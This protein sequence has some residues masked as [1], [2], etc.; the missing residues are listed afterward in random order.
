MTDG[1]SRDGAAGGSSPA[2]RMVLAIAGAAGC[3]TTAAPATAKTGIRASVEATTD[4]RRRGLS[5]SEGRAS[6]SGEFGADLGGI[7]TSVRV[8]ATRGS[9]RHAGADA[10]IDADVGKSFDLGPFRVR[11][12]AIGH[13]FVDA[14]RT[15]DYGELGADG[16]YSLGPVQVSAGAIWAPD[17]GAVGGDNLYLYAGA[18]A[19]IPGTP[20]TVSAAVGRTTGDSDDP[21]RSARLRP[22]G[23]YTDW[24]IGVA[25]VVGPLTLAVDYVAT[26]VDS[27]RVVSPLGDRGNSGDRILARAALAF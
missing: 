3:L 4:E 24:Q 11:G 9:V 6:I 13:F 27:S 14:G 19:G 18:N 21:V 16:S 12:R 26:D 8:A 7:E 22:D 1:Y 10:V 5:W 23:D 2:A 20:F 15:M 25:H 17:Q